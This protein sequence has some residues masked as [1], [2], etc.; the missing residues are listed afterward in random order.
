MCERWRITHNIVI[1]E[2][3][4]RCLHIENIHSNKIKSCNNHFQNLRYNDYEDTYFR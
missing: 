3:N 1:F 2:M 4:L